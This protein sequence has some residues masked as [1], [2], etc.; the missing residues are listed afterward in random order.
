MNYT[1]LNSLSEVGYESLL[2]VLYAEDLDRSVRGA[3]GQPRAVEVHLG[4]MLEIK[5]TMTKQSIACNFGIN[6]QLNAL[7]TIV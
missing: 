1:D 3:C 7:L 6:H 2:T 5:G 4:I